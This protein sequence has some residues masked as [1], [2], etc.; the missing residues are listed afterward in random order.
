ME[1]SEEKRPIR[2]E[3]PDK[4]M[5]KVSSFPSMPR[6][7]IKLRAILAEKDVSMDDIEG[8]LRH[9]PGL[10]TN[11]LRIANSAYF[12]LP[13]KVKTLKHAVILLGIKRFS[14]IAVS[15]CMSKTMDKAVEGYGLSPGEL[16]LH[17][18]AVS[19]TAEALAKY[20][21]YAETNDVFTPAL[22]HDMGKLILGEFVKEELQKIQSIVANG[23]PLDIAENMVLGTDHAEIGALILGKWSFPSDL[24][25]AVRW[26]HNP[27]SIKNSNLQAEIVYL[28]NLLCQSNVDRDSADGQFI[29]PSSVVLDR[30][31]IKLDQYEVFAEKADSWIKKLSDKLTFE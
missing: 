8:I 10:A 19:N 25:N 28:A 30:L 5:M 29:T 17:S 13:T 7:G 31:G 12:G 4:I 16:W 3:I 27:E 6:A 24:V 15:A 21:K 22:L 18:I 1:S 26:H 11:V 2:N 20:I 14:Q 9:D 23:V